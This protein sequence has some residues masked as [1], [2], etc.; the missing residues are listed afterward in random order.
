MTC[1]IA[2]N[3]TNQSAGS[4]HFSQD[5]VPSLP[6]FYRTVLFA[7]TVAYKCT[8]LWLLC[9]TPLQGTMTLTQVAS[10]CAFLHSHCHL[11]SMAHDSDTS[12]VRVHFHTSPLPIST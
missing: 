2:F 4:V 8:S 6:S 11:R 7:T 5:L 12:R 3:A 1:S 10:D 9:P